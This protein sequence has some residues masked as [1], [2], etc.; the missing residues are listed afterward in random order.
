MLRLFECKMKVIKKEEAF[1]IHTTRTP[2]VSHNWF[3]EVL[4]LG[5]FCDAREVVI[6]HRK[7][8][9]NFA[10]RFCPLILLAIGTKLNYFQ[11]C[12]LHFWISL[13]DKISLEKKGYLLLPSSSLRN[14]IPNPTKMWNLFSFDIANKLQFQLSKQNH[15]RLTH[16]LTRVFLGETVKKIQKKRERKI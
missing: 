15:K 5:Q 9:P 10:S 1:Q 3:Q 13:F 2:I 4:I 14:C 16:I 7:I 6:I 11:I 8:L 12:I